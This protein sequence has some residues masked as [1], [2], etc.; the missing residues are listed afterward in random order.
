MREYIFKTKS[1]KL[2]VT[3]AIGSILLVLSLSM[4]Y[5][6]A[7]NWISEWSESPFITG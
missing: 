1:K 4:T 7:L 2:F 6:L 5:L 3:L